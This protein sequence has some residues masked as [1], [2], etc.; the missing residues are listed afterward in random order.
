MSLVERVM[1]EAV[2][3]RVGEGY[4]LAEH[5]PPQFHAHAG[6]HPGGKQSRCDG[7]GYHQQR[8]G[9]HLPAGDQ[10][11]SLLERAQ[12]HTQGLIFLLHEQDGHLIGQHIG[13]G[14]IL[15]G[16]GLH[17]GNQLRLEALAACLFRLLHQNSGLRPL[18][19]HL[20]EGDHWQPKHLIQTAQSILIR[21][22]QRVGSLSVRGIGRPER[23]LIFVAQ[24]E[25]QRLQCVPTHPL[26]RHPFHAALLDA[27]IHNVR[28]V[29][30][31][32]QIAI[33][34]HAQ[35]RQNYQHHAPMFF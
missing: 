25:G 9:H 31:Q 33:C 19:L 12:I 20:V 5:P 28:R 11:I 32:R 22:C 16:H 27:H 26:G 3:L 8:D 1:R 15:L 34:L 10:Q 29:S 18:L 24:K 6:R 4:H 35:Q 7:S 30:G 17:P 2:D 21:F 13:S 14:A 23:R